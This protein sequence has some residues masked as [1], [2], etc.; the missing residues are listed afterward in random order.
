VSD[1]YNSYGSSAPP[2]SQPTT[3]VPPRP[4]A[5][6]IAR[7]QVSESWKRKFRLI[8]K[9]GGPDLPHFR[10]L[11]F[12]ERFGLSFN[13]IALILGPLYYLTKGLWRQALLYFIIAAA[14]ILLLNAIG[15]GSFSRNVGYGLGVVYASRANISYY[16]KVA[17][18]ET[19]W[20]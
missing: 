10:D 16:K 8:E 17:L 9:A 15:L 12:G 5:D 14:L 3:T 19:P 11:T 2:I 6:S 4:K 1:P 13:V 7:L 18:G 20:L